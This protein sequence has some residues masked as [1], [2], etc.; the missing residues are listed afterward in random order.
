MKL[1]TLLFGNPTS[2]TFSR[3]MYWKHNSNQT[4]VTRPEH[5]GKG[6]V[7][8]GARHRMENKKRNC[9]EVQEMETKAGV[10]RGLLQTA[11]MI[12]L[13]RMETVQN[14][15]VTQP[16][17]LSLHKIPYHITYHAYFK[18]WEHGGEDRAQSGLEIPFTLFTY[19]TIHVSFLSGCQDTINT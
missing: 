12:K 10:A 19:R 8:F 15:W 9:S 1:L 3:S 17:Y 13:R 6:W 4:D 16:L 5:D 11:S 14:P 2:T 7:P 18:N